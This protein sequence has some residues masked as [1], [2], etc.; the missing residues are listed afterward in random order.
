MIANLAELRR[1]CMRPVSWKQSSGGKEK[2]YLSAG[3][4]PRVKT[5]PRKALTHSHSWVCDPGHPQVPTASIEVGWSF[6]VSTTRGAHWSLRTA[7]AA[8]TL[9]SQRQQLEV[10]GEDQLWPAHKPAEVTPGVWASVT[11]ERVR[12]FSDRGKTGK[13]QMFGRKIKSFVQYMLSLRY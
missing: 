6:T 8:G 9:W 4:C 5:F 12:T 10:A 1:D 7:A 13:D 11:R 3:S 2:E